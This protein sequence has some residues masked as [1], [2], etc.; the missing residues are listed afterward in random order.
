M[1]QPV[2]MEDI[3]LPVAQFLGL[4]SIPDKLQHD[5]GQYSRYMLL[6]RRNH[7]LIVIFCNGTREDDDLI[8]IIE[9]VCIPHH[10]LRTDMGDS[11]MDAASTVDSKPEGIAWMGAPGDGLLRRQGKLPHATINRDQTIWTKFRAFRC[12]GMGKYIVQQLR[13]P[14]SI[15]IVNPLI[16]AVPDLKHLFRRDVQVAPLEIIDQHG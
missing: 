12:R 13:F 5:R 15:G 16:D 11:H 9:I 1:L 6:C 4:L 10:L 14:H 8:F 3:L 2:I 7:I